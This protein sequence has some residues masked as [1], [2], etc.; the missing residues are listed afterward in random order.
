M[1]HQRNTYHELAITIAT[2]PNAII[3]KDAP[4]ANFT[5]ADFR[6]FATREE[7]IMGNKWYSMKNQPEA[8]RNWQDITTHAETLA[9]LLNHAQGEYKGFN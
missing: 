7:E 2:N 8:E 9:V 4:G 5:P 1:T 6:Y 3:P